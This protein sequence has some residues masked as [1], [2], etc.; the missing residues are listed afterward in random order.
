MR[1][2]ITP[3]LLAA[4]VTVA[5][6]AASADVVAHWQMDEG[7]G[8]AVMIDSAP[9][10]GDNHGTI[11]NVTTG[12]PGLVSGNAYSFSGETAYVEVPDADGLDPGSS[13]IRLTATVLAVNVPMPDDSYD[14]VRKGYSTT[15]GGDW[16]MEI[17]R[18][19]NN[20]SVGR[21][22]CSFK[23]VLPD[24]RR[25]TVARVAQVDIIDGRTHTLQ[26]LRTSTGVTALVDGRAFTKSGASGS[27]A[28]DQP[29]VVG[30]KM[31]GDDVL[32]GTLDEVIVDIG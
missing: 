25:R 5:P 26:C 2:W 31:S 12:V 23:G 13:T 28:N 32:Q 24:G 10:G 18:N 8:A 9:L 14:L 22:H 3:A 16:K 29:V 21:L 19:P 1:T 17:K 6:T 15:R 30:A 11:V 7:A 4:A 27:I 20:H